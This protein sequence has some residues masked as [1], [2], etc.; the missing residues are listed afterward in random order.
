MWFLLLYEHENHMESYL[1]FNMESSV[2]TARP[3]EWSLVACSLFV[4][5]D[6]L[7]WLFACLSMPPD[8]ADA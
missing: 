5:G 7:E 8:D 1:V 6:F 3:P 2:S 4:L